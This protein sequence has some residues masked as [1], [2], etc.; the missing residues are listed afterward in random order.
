MYSQSI[1]ES[2][3]HCVIWI[4]PDEDP[5]WLKMKADKIRGRRVTS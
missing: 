4:T 2:N 5:E 3:Y 1:S